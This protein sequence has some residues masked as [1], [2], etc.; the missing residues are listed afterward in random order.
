MMSAHFLNEA[1]ENNGWRA[2]NE[3]ATTDLLF[4]DL[5][6][7]LLWRNQHL[8]RAFSGRFQLSN[9]TGQPSWNPV[10]RTIE[11]TGQYFVLRGPI[12]HGL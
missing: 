12:P 9:W 7:I 11:N 3:D 6:G 1:V 5:G 4:F 8:Q 2:Y 10:S